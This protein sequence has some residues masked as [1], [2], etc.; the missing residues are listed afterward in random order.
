M[1]L[2]VLERP[3]AYLRP[4]V[5]LALASYGTFP[6]PDSLPKAHFFDSSTACSTRDRDL[7]KTA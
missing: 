3:V 2:Y 5:F 1:A 7:P 6:T 4:L